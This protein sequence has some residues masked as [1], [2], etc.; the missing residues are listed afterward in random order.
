MMFKT[1][2]TTKSEQIFQALKLSFADYYLPLSGDFSEH[3]ERWKMAGVDLALSY[4]AFDHDELLGFVLV[5]CQ[6]KDAF[7]LATGVIPE[8][9]GQAITRK[10]FEHLIPQ[11]KTKGLRQITLEV[12][13]QNKTAIKVYTDAGFKIQRSLFSFSGTPHI[14]LPVKSGSYAI[15]PYALKREHLMLSIFPSGFEQ[16]FD[17]L[18]RQK[19]KIELHELR[20]NSELRA[21]AL[22]NPSRM[23]L[24]YLGGVNELSLATLLT[25]MKLDGE[26]WGMIN[27][28][29]KNKMLTQ[30]FSSIGLNHYLTQFEMRLDL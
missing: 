11:L 25:E 10:I 24:L 17:V 13:D 2:E 5:A 6:G 19:E 22:F 14:H 15:K 8:A 26:R 12:I 30:I 18:T 29:A 16:S 28:D 9:R 4:G 27:V 21:F 1:L 3:Q 23:N 20:E 7:N